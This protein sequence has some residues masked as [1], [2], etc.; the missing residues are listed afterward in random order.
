MKN[1]Y[2][3]LFLEE[4]IKM[5]YKVNKTLSGKDL[6]DEYDKLWDWLVTAGHASDNIP[7]VNKSLIGH[8]LTGESGIWHV[9]D[10]LFNPK[11]WNPQ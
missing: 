3:M 9:L 11:V 7:W 4:R 10:Y 5:D 1:E 8:L 2:E 6:K